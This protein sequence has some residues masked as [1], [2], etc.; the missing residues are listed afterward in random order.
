M[1][2]LYMY[3]NIHVLPC[4]KLYWAESSPFYAPYVAQTMSRNRFELLSDYFHLN[5]RAQAKEKG[6]DGYDPL[7]K[8][9]PILK[10]TQTTFAENYNPGQNITVDEAMIACKCRCGFLQYMPAK[11]TRWGIKV[12]ACC[13]SSSFYM[14][15][16]R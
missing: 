2:G 6:Q 12:W 13:D 16:Y 8:V 14:L 3:M 9:R 4:L 11:P 7:Y 15:Q 1:I 5:D 10:L